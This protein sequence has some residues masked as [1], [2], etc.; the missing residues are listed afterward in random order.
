MQSNIKEIHSLITEQRRTYVQEQKI[1]VSSSYLRLLEEK[2]DGFNRDN[3]VKAINSLKDFDDSLQSLVYSSFLTYLSIFTQENL[4]NGNDIP[5]WLKLVYRNQSSRKLSLNLADNI[6]SLFTFFG[7]SLEKIVEKIESPETLYSLG[8]YESI[9]EILEDEESQLFWIL[10]I[11]PLGYDKKDFLSIVDNLDISEDQK[12]LLK[13]KYAVISIKSKGKVSNWT[14]FFDKKQIQANGVTKDN[15][16]IYIQILNSYNFCAMKNKKYDL[17]SSAFRSIEKI[18]KQMDDPT[19][20][21]LKGI[22][23]YHKSMSLLKKNRDESISYLFSAMK[24]DKGFFDYYYRMG[25]IFYENN[26]EIARLCFEIAV[27]TSPLPL[28]II[29]DYGYLL[30]EQSPELADQWS[31]LIIKMK[32]FKEED[33]Q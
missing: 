26:L 10:K 33:F 4:T 32:I 31:R 15:A 13:A 11:N 7:I 3:F 12:A 23:S 19:G 20:D 16:H 18:N 30:A 9:F 28:E 2:I 14:D 24:S 29:N 17:V 6:R 1:E 8:Q 5:L 22:Y 21:H 27:A 25:N